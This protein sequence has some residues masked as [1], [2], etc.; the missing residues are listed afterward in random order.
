MMIHLRDSGL[1]SPSTLFEYNIFK[2]CYMMLAYFA[3]NKLD[4]R[5]FKYKAPKRSSNDV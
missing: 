1:E 4:Y 2:F 5:I 3:Y